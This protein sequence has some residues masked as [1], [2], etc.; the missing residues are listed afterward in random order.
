MNINDSSSQNPGQFPRLLIKTQKTPLFHL[1][2]CQI[3]SNRK[4]TPSALS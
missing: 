4:D 2:F 3:I 1:I